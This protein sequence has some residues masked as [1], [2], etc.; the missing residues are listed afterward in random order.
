M[1]TNSWMF[2]K[3]KVSDRTIKPV[4]CI[5]ADRFVLVSW[6]QLDISLR[7]QRL[8]CEKK[9]IFLMVIS[10]LL[11]TEGWLPPILLRVQHGSCNSSIKRWNLLSS[12][13]FQPTRL[14]INYYLLLDISSL[15]NR[16]CCIRSS[17]TRWL[18]SWHLEMLP[19]LSSRFNESRHN[20]G[21]QK[22]LIAM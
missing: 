15:C 6:D 19:E 17:L 10:R 21:W 22:F 1:F 18:R 12:Y 8:I 13:V 20:N 4:C 16:V 9:S 5:F 14:V 11:I 7:W 3:L 2:M